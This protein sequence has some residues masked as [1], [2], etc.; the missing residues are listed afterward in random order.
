MKA[1]KYWLI[2]ITTLFSVQ[3]YAYLFL[4]QIINNTESVCKLDSYDL[5]H[6]VLYTYP[7]PR[8]LA[9]QSAGFYLDRSGFRGIEIKLNYTCGGKKIC[10]TSHEHLSFISAAQ[11]SAQL[12]YADSGITVRAETQE[13]SYNRD[14]GGVVNWFIEYSK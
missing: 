12:N 4:V 3:S 5:I 2:A 6:G 10:F 11:V 9:G 13:G 14:R 7:S 8:L 1:I